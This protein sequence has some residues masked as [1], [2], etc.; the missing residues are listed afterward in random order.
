MTILQIADICLFIF[1]CKWAYNA[2][3]SA[4]EADNTVRQARTLLDKAEE[5]QAAW[6]RAV[7]HITREN[8]EDNLHL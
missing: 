4:K 7:K 6:E 8:Y 5:H 3:T 2:Y 1:T